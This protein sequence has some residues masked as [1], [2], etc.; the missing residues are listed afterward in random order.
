MDKKFYLFI[1]F[2]FLLSL[3]ASAQINADIIRPSVNAEQFGLAL[4]AETALSKGQLSLSIPLMELK[5]KGY[6]LPI[7]LAFYSGDVT[8]STESSPIGLGWALMAG[9]VIKMTIR[10]GDDI[11]SQHQGCS[12][13]HL[14][15]GDYLY[16]EYL[17]PQQYNFDFLYD[18]RDNSAPDEYSYSLPGH[19]GVIEASYSGSTIKMSLFPDESYKLESVN[20]GYCI[21]DDRGN[22]FYFET[23]E[24][25]V[26]NLYSENERQTTTYFLTR[27]LTAKGG[28]FTFTYADE[29]Y[30]DLT[31]I[32][33][34]SDFL[35][36]HTKRITSIVSDFGSVQFHSAPRAD[37]GDLNNCKIRPGKES[38]RINKIELRDENGNFVKGYELD[39]SGLFELYKYKYD[40]QDYNWS[41][42]RMKLSSV[43]QYD[44]AGNRLPP[45]N[46]SYS[47]KLSKSGLQY[48]IYDTANNGDYI[49]YDSWTSCPGSQAYVDLTETGAPLCSIGNMPHAVPVGIT[50]K[51]EESD[52]NTADDFFCLNSITYPNGAIDEFFYQKHQYGKVNNYQEPYCAEKIQGRCL[53]SKISYGSNMYRHIK[54]LYLLHDANYN[55]T[56]QL[57]GV[58][59]NPSIHCATYYTPDTDSSRQ[60]ML[61]ASRVT[62]GRPFNTFMG[63]PVCYTEVEE[64]EFDEYDNLLYKNIHY[65]EPQIVSPPVNYVLVASPWGNHFVEIENQ[66]YG[67]KSGYTGYLAGYN[68]RNLTYMA[69]PVGD[70]SNAAIIADKPLKEVLIGKDGDVRRVKEYFY[71]YDNIDKTKKYGYK[72]VSEEKPDQTL[73]LISKTEYIS[74][75]VRPSGYHTTLYFQNGDVRDSI[76]ETCSMYYKKGRTSGTYYSRGNDNLNESKYSE[77]YYPDEIN[78]ITG[79]NAS[80][81]LAAVNGLIGKN[82]VADPIK[83]IERRNGEIVGGEC[84]EYQIFSGKPLLKSLYKV[85]NTTNKW[86]YAPTVSGSSLDYHADLYKEGEVLA[87]DDNQNPAYVRLNDTQDRIY[88]WG[89][90]GRFPIAVIDNMSYATYLSLSDL[91]T[92]I[93]ALQTYQKIDGEDGCTALRNL[94][95]S[96][97]ALLPQS[98]HITTYTYDPY[99]GMT[100][101]TD[102]SNLGVIYTYDSFGR[103]TAKYDENYKKLE[104]Y[105]YHLKLQE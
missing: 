96:I 103:L 69:Y 100:S 48:T 8:S 105:N 53:S 13:T 89:Y 32:R 72:I 42:Y 11:E 23:A 82:M 56:D 84:R 34:E 33:D 45:H 47:Y 30:I 38:K 91:K 52:Y 35:Q 3:S 27:I 54:Y 24:C 15:D 77:Y 46:F 9:G 26:S 88:V 43:T 16:K 62:S 75:K 51:K 6:D 22:K 40:T 10:G 81:L 74:P 57:S 12:S 1:L 65:F 25:Y 20:T 67:I 50:T 98:A 63:P 31:S 66:I 17:K 44:A 70:F 55:T 92:K 19:N 90:G 95:G 21:T 7:S 101:E 60:W 76:C 28:V 37:R 79:N 102:D 87:Y 94:N 104:E 80:P 64:A 93:L 29:D 5:G 99:V 41:D 78:N 4:K 39:N 59:T 58:L 86:S 49:P 18:I 83:T 97:R 71:V 73:H 68:S 2:Y 14:T 36:Y 85:K 61:R